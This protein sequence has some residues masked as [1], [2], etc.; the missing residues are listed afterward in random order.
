M[1]ST[2]R[3]LNRLLLIVVGLVLIG[4][5]ALTFLV[6]PSDALTFAEGYVIEPLWIVIGLAVV[7]VLLLVFVFRQGHGHT[8]RL[9]DDEP[10]EHGRTVIDSSVA[11][12]AVKDALLGLPD[13]V[14]ASVSTYRVRRTPTLKIAVTCRRGASPVDIVAETRRTML[15]LDELLGEQIPANLQISG[16]FRARVAPKRKLN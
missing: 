16:G 11:E 9:I 13:V 5:G 3:A 4:L 15:A 2:N 14:A 8:G 6:T 7:V 10:T 12:H 1:N